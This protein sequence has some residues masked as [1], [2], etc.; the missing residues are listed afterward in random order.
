MLMAWWE[1]D[2]P[3]SMSG[4]SLSEMSAR[5]AYHLRTRLGGDRVGLLVDPGAHDNLVGSRTADRMVQMLGVPSRTLRM[6]KALQVEGVGK[7]AQ[8]AST[9]RKMALRLCTDE[10]TAVNGSYT[11]PVI[12]D[13]DLPPLLGLKSLRN[14]GAILDMSKNQLILPGPASCTITRSPGSQVF[15]L[16]LSSSGHLILPIDANMQVSDAQ[17]SGLEFQMSCR[18]PSRSVSPARSAAPVRTSSAVAVDE[19]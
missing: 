7:S 13:S 11:A 4:D 18:K 8:S 1:V 6:D 3:E 16:K 17:E 10:G 14:F 15:D 19:S 9:A 2:S 12:A 5:E